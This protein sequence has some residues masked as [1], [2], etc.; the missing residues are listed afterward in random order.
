MLESEIVAMTCTFVDQ[1]MDVCVAA[2]TNWQYDAAAEPDSAAAI[3]PY[4]GRSYTP[5]FT[6]ASSGI[7]VLPDSLR[8]GHRCCCQLPYSELL[9]C[10]PG[11][12]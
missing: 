7:K 8:S 4:P 1:C 5:C 2:D 6:S 12:P 10:K 11:K 3:A 9:N